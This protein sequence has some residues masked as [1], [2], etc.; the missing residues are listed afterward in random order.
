MII[1]RSWPWNSSVL[2]TL[3]CMILYSK[4]QYITVQLHLAQPRPLQRPPQ[5]LHLPP[6][7]RDHTNFLFLHL[8]Y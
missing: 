2:P 4:N 6:V 5:L 8:H 1:L 7:R 3:T